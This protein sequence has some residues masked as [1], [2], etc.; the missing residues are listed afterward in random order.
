[1]SS[2]A[3]VCGAIFFVVYS[4]IGIAGNSITTI[5]LLRDRKIRQHSTTAFILSLCISDWIF[6]LVVMP[7]MA[8]AYM[9]EDL[10]SNKILCKLHISALMTNFSITMNSIA[11]IAINRYI[12]IVHNS[13]Y[14][15]VYRNSIVLPQLLIIWLLPSVLILFPLFDKWGTLGKSREYV[16]G[17]IIPCVIVGVL[18]ARINC[19]VRQQSKNMS[20]HKTLGPSSRNERNL[21]MMTLAIYVACL[22]C[23]VPVVIEHFWFMSLDN[24]WPNVIAAICGGL[25]FIIDPFIYAATNRKYRAAYRRLFAD[26]KFWDKQ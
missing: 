24:P 1:M 15:N 2:A 20:Q 5:A 17:G 16:V 11:A 13:F 21:T 3:S 19:K 6:S 9:N 25:I 26:M 22:V 23:C 12:L 7:L 4:I 10:M 8:A 14:K 18:Y